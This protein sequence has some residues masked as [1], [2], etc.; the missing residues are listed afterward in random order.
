MACIWIFQG[1]HW[2]GCQKDC[3]VFVP[4]CQ[5]GRGCAIGSAKARA[6]SPIQKKML[7]YGGGAERLKTTVHPYLMNECTFCFNLPK[8]P[9]CCCFFV[10]SFWAVFLEMLLKS[11][12]LC[13]N[14]T[15][16]LYLLRGVFCIC[17]GDF[18]QPLCSSSGI[19]Y[20]LGT[21]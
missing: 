20:Y 8:V 9:G 15:T 16:F 11:Y 10:F 7:R 21:T 3:L 13:S 17:Y 1:Y 19:K 6:R 5:M 4:Q 18:G 14:E 2:E 12:T